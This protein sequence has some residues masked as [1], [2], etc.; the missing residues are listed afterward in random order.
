MSKRPNRAKLKGR[1]QSGSFT[2]LPHAVQESAN[3]CACGKPARAL[4]VDI[5][6]QYRGTNNGDLCAAVTTLK[7]FG[8]TRGETISK[9]LRELR[10]YGL[11]Q[12]TRQGGLNRPSL[13]AIT[14]QPID[15]CGGKLD[16]KETRVAPGT[17]KEPR[18]KYQRPR[19]AEKLKRHTA[20]RHGLYRKAAL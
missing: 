10:H 6:R 17:W 9:L 7:P 15:E 4:L 2:A 18:E 1:K 19:R 16:A 13:Y 12:L 20:K 5:A 8:W 3:W 11:L 14:W